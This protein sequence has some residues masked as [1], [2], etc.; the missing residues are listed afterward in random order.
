MVNFFQCFKILFQILECCIIFLISHVCFI[1]SDFSLIPLSCCLSVTFSLVFHCLV[2]ST[3][4]Y[5][6]FCYYL[7]FIIY[8]SFPLCDFN[9]KLTVRFCVDLLW[10]KLTFFLN[11]LPTC[12]P[13]HFQSHVAFLYVPSCIL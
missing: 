10:A 3:I 1:F 5:Y 2:L 9:S 11:K 13:I 12:N 6:K 8:T 4:I 7:M